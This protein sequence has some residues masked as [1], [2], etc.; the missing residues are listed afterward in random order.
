[1]STLRT[2]CAAVVFFISLPGMAASG[3]TRI[4]HESKSSYNT[5]IVT[6]DPDGLRNM[7]FEKNGARQSAIRPD[8][9][10]H[11]ELAYSRVAL[12]GLALCDE[13]ESFLVF[14]LGG[15][16]IPMFLKT[17]FPRAHIDVVDIDPAVIDAARQ[18]FGFREDRRMVAYA[19]DARAFAEKIGKSRYDVI[20]L[21][22][23]GRDTVPA[24]LT[25]VEFLQT[26]RAALKPG[27]VAV[28][29]LWSRVHNRMYDAMVRTYQEAFAD[30]YILDSDQAS[31]RL[32]LAL[33]RTEGISEYDL[34]SRAQALSHK[35]RFR[36]D[37]GR[38]VQGH[39]MH[40]NVRDSTQH[41]LRDAD[42]AGR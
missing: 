31:N 32:L 24:H 18:Y 8:D 13:P 12:A 29:N 26:V 40:A 34:V 42:S 16:A 25:T 1:M 6:E 28:G 21:D 39:F 2:I 37:V 11:L 5:I 15:G 20:F 17:H 4:L 7:L 19:E 27:G 10:G 35:A 41:V 14:G 38:L 23:F 22:A 33:P 30:L 3:E 36:F 9:P